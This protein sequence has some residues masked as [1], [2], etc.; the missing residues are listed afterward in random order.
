MVFGP[1]L[2]QQLLATAKL[3]AT[4]RTWTLE[5]V[6]AYAID[7]VEGQPAPNTGLVSP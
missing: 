4:C 2:G 7:L 3:P 5:H 1:R 6:H